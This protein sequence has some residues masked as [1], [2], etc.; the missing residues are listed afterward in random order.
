MMRTRLL[1]VAL[2]CLVTTNAN[3]QDKTVDESKP[4]LCRGYYHSEEDAVAQL[5]RMAGTYSNL[6]QWEERAAAIRKQI[7]VGANL[8]PLPNRT[9]LNPTI[10]KKREYEGYTVESAAFEARPG[11]LVYGSLYRPIGAKGP[12]P[13]ILCPHGHARG[14]EGVL[15]V[16]VICCHV[17]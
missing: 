15:R 6:D 10:H 2:V 14:P 7:L 11:Y 12:H 4:I 8:D 16:D 5:A 1:L 13:A 9:P 17:H 3:T